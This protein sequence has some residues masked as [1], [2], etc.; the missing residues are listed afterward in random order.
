MGTRGPAPRQPTATIKFR[1]GVPGPLPEL[2]EEGRA[3]Y[4]RICEEL[5]AADASLQQVDRGVVHLAAYAWER[6]LR[7]TREIGERGEIVLGAQGQEV[8][9]PRVKAYELAEAS[10]LRAS[11]KL[12]FSP[13]DR[14]RVPKA[15]AS[16][17]E[18]P[19]G[20]FASI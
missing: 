5:E 19:S 4:V 15:A 2:N 18:D 16:S 20:S 17:R 6:I 12:G 1:P 3:E 10:Y 11:A 7:L 14:A 8:L 9:S 13:A